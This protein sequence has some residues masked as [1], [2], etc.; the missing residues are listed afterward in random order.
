MLKYE[1]TSTLVHC[2]STTTLVF[3]EP[4][5]GGN[6][7]RGGTPLGGG[8]PSSDLKVNKN[9][10]STAPVLHYYYYYYKSTSTRKVVVKSIPSKFLGKS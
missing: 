9:N 4:R 2:T 10:T 7:V 8:T 5:Q 3:E 6:P 1:Y